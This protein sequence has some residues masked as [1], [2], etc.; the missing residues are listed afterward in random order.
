MQIISSC[1]LQICR[2]MPIICKKYAKICNYIDCISRI[3]KNYAVKICRYKQFYMQ[4]MQNLKSRAEVRS[5][6]ITTT[7]REESQ[8]TSQGRHR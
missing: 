4:D 7:V 1:M 2:Y 3:C 6:F 5:S 8:V